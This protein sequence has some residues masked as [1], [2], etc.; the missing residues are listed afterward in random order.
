[1]TV[2]R[3]HAVCQ[4]KL[5]TELWGDRPIYHVTIPE[6]APIRDSAR[7]EAEQLGNLRGSI[8]NGDGNFA[9]LLAEFVVADSIG[10][11]RRP[12]Y[13]YDIVR[14]DVSIDVKTK[15]RTVKPKPSYEA[16]IADYNTEQGADVY[17]F[18]SYNT[19][20]NVF[21]LLGYVTT[22]NYYQMATF[23]EEGDYDADNNF[24]FK[25]D[26]YNLRYDKLRQCDLR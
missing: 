2:D 14:N 13:E 5:K 23:H 1:M 15:R 18:T 11:V 12:T 4:R 26:C 21:S 7:Q 3:A 10:A 25:A 17:Y 20:S 6:D 19:D 24:T 9:G 22:D 8:E 16:S